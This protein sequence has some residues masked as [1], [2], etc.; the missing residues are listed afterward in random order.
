MGIRRTR[1]ESGV[2]HLRDRVDASGCD[3][4]N[5]RMHHSAVRNFKII[6]SRAHAESGA[7]GTKDEG[8]PIVLWQLP[9]EQQVGACL[10]LLEVDAIDH[11]DD[12]RA[13]R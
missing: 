9:I 10:E 12:S 7:C 11:V 13:S 2:H 6:R 3:L 4:A 1:P 5:W 8:R